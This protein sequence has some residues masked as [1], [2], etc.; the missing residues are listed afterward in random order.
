MAKKASATAENVSVKHSDPNAPTVYAAIRDFRHVIGGATV[1]FT[2]GKPIT[3]ERI[4]AALIQ[5]EAPIA[6]LDPSKELV[7]CP[8]CGVLFVNEKPAEN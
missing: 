2:A 3:D 1:A 5:A 8:H 7:R 6:P 4:L